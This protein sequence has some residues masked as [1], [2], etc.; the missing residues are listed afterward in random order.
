MPPWQDPGKL[1]TL[2][3]LPEVEVVSAQH[4]ELFYRQFFISQWYHISQQKKLL[5]VHS[6][7][8]IHL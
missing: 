2:M 6:S 4:P 8:Q 7:E 1:S 5:M 3:A